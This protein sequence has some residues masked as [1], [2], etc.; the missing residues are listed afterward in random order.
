MRIDAKLGKEISAVQS[1]GH[2]WNKARLDI[3]QQT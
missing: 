1:N 3:S 2:G